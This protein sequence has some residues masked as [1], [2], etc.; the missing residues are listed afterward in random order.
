MH[1]YVLNS[2]TTFICRLILFFYGIFF[3]KMKNLNTTTKK[4]QKKLCIE[5]V[6]EKKR[7]IKCKEAE[8]ILFSRVYPHVCTWIYI[9]V[10]VIDAVIYMR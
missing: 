8:V 2:L 3:F 4:K 6:H 9:A 1:L 7:E 10:I 5:N